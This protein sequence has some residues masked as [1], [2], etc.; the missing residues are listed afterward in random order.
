[1]TC[2]RGRVVSV[3][4]VLAIV[5]ASAGTARAELSVLDY[6]SIQQGNDR[7]RKD[8][9]RLYLSGVLEGLLTFNELSRSL[10]VNVFCI[11]QHATIELPAFQKGVDEAIARTKEERS[12][13][14]VYAEEANISV[15]GL[16]A[17]NQAYPCR[18]Q[19]DSPRTEPDS[20]GTAR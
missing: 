10:Q 12:D 13:F 18:Q 5:G 7:E 20:G 8:D 9:L 3:L 16:V 14:S 2:R 6:L 17:L 15:M 4:L 11:P 19:D 1:M